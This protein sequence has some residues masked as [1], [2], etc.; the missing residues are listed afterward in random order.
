MAR[1]AF[2][3][4]SSIAL[5][6]IEATSGLCDDRGR[7]VRTAWAS[8]ENIC[9]FLL[10]AWKPGFL[11]HAGLTELSTRQE[12]ISKPATKKPRHYAHGFF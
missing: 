1:L 5:R 8:I 11:S 4:N 2:H 9:G 12:D 6:Y 10:L 3:R 7:H